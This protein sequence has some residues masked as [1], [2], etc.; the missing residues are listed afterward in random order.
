M[1][2]AEEVQAV[3]DREHRF[4]EALVS[5]ERKMNPKPSVWS[6]FGTMVL[7]GLTSKPVAKMISE[8]LERWIRDIRDRPKNQP[9]EESE[10]QMIG[11]RHSSPRP[12]Q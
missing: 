11:F 8:G 3:F 9:D 6:G 2:T 5:A 1:V 4:R 12:D 7:K 10:S